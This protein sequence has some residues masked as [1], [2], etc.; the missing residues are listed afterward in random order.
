MVR[1]L[2]NKPTVT[3]NYY[4]SSEG[5]SWVVTEGEWEWPALWVQHE[6]DNE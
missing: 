2:G 3:R 1:Q 4:K 5:I 6:D